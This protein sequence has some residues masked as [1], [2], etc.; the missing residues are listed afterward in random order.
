MA[1]YTIDTLQT[2]GRLDNPHPPKWGAVLCDQDG[3]AVM[4]PGGGAAYRSD[5]HDTEQDAIDDLTR[6]LAAANAA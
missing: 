6:Q 2:C 4:K 1:D 5:L 3:Q